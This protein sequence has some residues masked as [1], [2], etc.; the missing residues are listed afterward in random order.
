M[1]KYKR[2][3]VLGRFVIQIVLDDARGFLI[4]LLPSIEVA[5]QHQFLHVGVGLGWLFGKLTFG[6]MR[7]TWVK[8][9]Y[10]RR[11][12]VQKYADERGI[13]RQVYED[14]WG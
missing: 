7:K 13:T 4:K 1:K 6:F 11:A 14:R 3:Y 12:R 2:T 8:G 5:I 10:E 9:E